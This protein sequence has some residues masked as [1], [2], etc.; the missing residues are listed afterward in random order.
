MATHDH[1]TGTTHEELIADADALAVKLYA[2]SRND[3]ASPAVRLVALDAAEELVE[4]LDALT[5]AERSTA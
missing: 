4:L 5:A 3:Q 2:L 1:T